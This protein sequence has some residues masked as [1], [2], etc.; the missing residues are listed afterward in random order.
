[1]VQMSRASQRLSFEDT[2]ASPSMCRDAGPDGP[3][4]EL[5]PS[6]GTLLTN[7]S[8]Y[9][10]KR[11]IQESMPECT[12]I[13]EYF[14]AVLCHPSSDVFRIGLAYV[15]TMAQLLCLSASIR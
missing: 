13:W 12:S 2:A 8:I 4:R 5:A 14:G 7:L 3:C 10:E 1:M 9:K 11:K 6:R 15:M